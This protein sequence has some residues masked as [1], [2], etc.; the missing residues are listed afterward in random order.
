VQSAVA[1]AALGVEE[2]VGGVDGSVVAEKGECC[3][4]DVRGRE[5][6]G[7]GVSET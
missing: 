5:T 3:A 1:A 6:L 2:A 4:C 7:T